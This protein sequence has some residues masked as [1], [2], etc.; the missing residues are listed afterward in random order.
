MI[1]PKGPYGSL[2]ISRSM[3]YRKHLFVRIGILSWAVVLTSKAVCGQQPGEPLSAWSPGMF[4]IHQIHTGRGNAA[5]LVFP[6]GTTA[7]VDAGGVPDRK[8]LEIGP[9]RPSASR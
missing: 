9:Q 2:W 3:K 1:A 8:G 6:D 7:L 5:L 4:D